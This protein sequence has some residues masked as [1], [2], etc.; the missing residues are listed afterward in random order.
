MKLLKEIINKLFLLRY[1]NFG[2][3]ELKECDLVDLKPLFKNN[4]FIYAADPF[5]LDEKTILFEGITWQESIGKIYSFNKNSVNKISFPDNVENLHMSYPFTLTKNNNFYIIPQ[6]SNFN[7]LICFNLDI[8]N[9]KASFHSELLK[10]VQCR[11]SILFNLNKFDFIFSTVLDSNSNKVF[12]VY[13]SVKNKNNFGEY[14]FSGLKNNA[15]CAG[16]I[17]E[18]DDKYYLPIQND[19]PIYG[20][21]ISIYRMYFNENNISFVFEKSLNLVCEKIKKTGFHTISKHKNKYLIDFRYSKY[22]PLAFYYK[23]KILT[24]NFIRKIEFLNIPRYVFLKVFYNINNW[25]LNSLLGY[26]RYYSVVKNINDKYDFSSVNEIGCG[27]SEINK[28]IKFNN[29]RGF[30]IDSNIIKLPKILKGGKISH[31][32]DIRKSVECTIMINF[33]HNLNINKIKELYNTIKD[34]KYVIVDEIYKHS[35]GYKY[36]HDFGKVFNQ[37]KLKSSSDV[38]NG[39]RRILLYEK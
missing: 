17:I 23:L 13:R 16:K 6:I 1:W 8:K 19:K 27:L 35:L 37:H 38:F 2:T 10:G 12:K 9:L 18:E 30:D 31:I 11:D 4:N 21:G 25:H 15:R 24:N 26:P 7:S 39:K 20:S 28:S 14:E 3:V 36:K 33:L 34:S 32:D 5:F 29:Y 22:Y